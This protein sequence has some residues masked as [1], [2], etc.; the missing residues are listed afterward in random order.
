MA[1]DASEIPF[2]GSTEAETQAAG[3]HLSA[4]AAVTPNLQLRVEGRV[5]WV[6]RTRPG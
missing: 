1:V 4:S 5:D 2:P 3:R 6:K